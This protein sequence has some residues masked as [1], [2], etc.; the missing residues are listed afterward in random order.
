MIIEIPVTWNNDELEELKKYD[1]VFFFLEEYYTLI[2]QFL[3]KIDTRKINNLNINI[4]SNKKDYIN[5]E[6]R[7]VSLI[8]VNNNFLRT[9]IKLEDKYYNFEFHNSENI[10]YEIYFEYNNIEI[11]YVFNKE[12][13]LKI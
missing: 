4:I 5:L 12:K 10:F 13:Y 2:A 7:I 11:I 6:A 3:R 9:K 8:H 1:N